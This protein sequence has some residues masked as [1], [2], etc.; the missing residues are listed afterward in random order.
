LASNGAPRAESDGLSEMAIGRL[1]VQTKEEAAIVI[2][3]IVGY[4][5]G[6]LGNSANYLF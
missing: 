5:E 3:K 6:L 1:P 2:S 4:A